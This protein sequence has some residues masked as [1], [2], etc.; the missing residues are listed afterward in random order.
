[1][2]RGFSVK[3]SSK[4]LQNVIFRVKFLTMTLKPILMHLIAFDR[5]L[6][7]KIKLIAA[8]RMISSKIYAHELKMNAGDLYKNDKAQL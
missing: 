5:Q 3:C 8:T 1:M 7:R 2:M 4:N 6:Y